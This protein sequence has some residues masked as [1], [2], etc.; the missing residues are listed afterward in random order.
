MTPSQMSEPQAGPLIRALAWARD[1]DPAALTEH[2]RAIYR[3]YVFNSPLAC[4]ISLYLYLMRPD[5]EPWPFLRAWVFG[6]VVYL[7]SRLVA[8]VV[9]SLHPPR[10]T[11]ALPFWSRLSIVIQALDGLFVT[12]L[13]LFIYPELDPLAQS[14]VLAAALVMVGATAF[15]L[16]SRWI[17]IL[18]YAPPVYL[19]F[20]WMTW[21]QGHAYA[22][23]FAVF[24]LSMFGL[25]LIYASNQRKSV[26]KGFEL[27]KLNGQL[28]DQLHAKNAELQ[29]VATGRSRL[30]A[31]VSH[32]LRQPAHAIGLLAERALCDSSP[33]STRQSLRDLNELSKSLSA[34]LIT[35]MDLT[36][37]DAG[38]VEPSKMPL[39]L[40]QVFKRLEAE[41]EAAALSKGLLFLVK[42]A[43]HWVRSDP[44]LLHGLLANLVS[45]ALKYTAHGMVELSSRIEGD[46]VLISV[47]DTGIGVRSDKLEIIFKEFVRLD[48]SESGTEGLGLGLSIVKRYA[49]L[50]GHRLSVAS[51]PGQGSRFS[52]CL[53]L[54]DPQPIP[55]DDAGDP[56]QVQL[57]HLHVLVVDNVDL[58]LSSMVKTLSGWGSGVASAHNMVEAI[59]ASRDRPVDLLISDYHLGDLEPNG[60]Q[61]IQTL[62]A[63]ADRA[64][65]A[66]L[67]T[68]DVSAQ[69]EASAHSQ[70][71]R[72]L[73]KPVRPQVL[74]DQVLEILEQARS[75]Q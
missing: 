46:Q 68:G 4:A 1:E 74:R 57:S 54:T 64:L 5:T 44:V 58:L 26:L 12:A 32:D 24:T 38:L 31:T 51:T 66:L 37:L 21:Q 6:W 55:S 59:E 75:V 49:I 41:F 72:V 36:R 50:L 42:S 53:P 43:D 52:V 60:L 39:S 29:E 33:A 62:R 10:S 22:H 20:A 27:A 70:G 56:A 69:L 7:A 13:A 14:A 35:L 67:L 48:A 25:Y 17:S 2:L 19:S 16:A 15:S 28:A 40:E 9:F 45:N 63:R 3:D 8:G 61:L 30:L 47:L 18:V 71:V 23:G 34:S 73:H 11:Q 65:P